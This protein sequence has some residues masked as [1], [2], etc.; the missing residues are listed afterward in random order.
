M[1]LAF[2]RLGLGWLPE[3]GFAWA[4]AVVEPPAGVPKSFVWSDETTRH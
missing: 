1:E 2:G 3:P 4:S